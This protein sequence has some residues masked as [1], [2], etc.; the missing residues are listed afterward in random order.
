MGTSRNS[1]HHT[2]LARAVKQGYVSLRFPRPSGVFA[3]MS[4]I[5]LALSGIP[6]I[7]AAGK[8]RRSGAPIYRFRRGS[9]HRGI[10]TEIYPGLD[11]A[12]DAQQGS[13]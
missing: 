5:E 7:E 13:I 6:K 11:P 2:C 3:T 9:S 1:I 8:T 12:G 10:G 4:K